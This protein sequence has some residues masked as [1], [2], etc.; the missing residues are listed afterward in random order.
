MNFA[1]KNKTDYLFF[2]QKEKI[3]FAKYQLLSQLQS[4]QKRSV[5]LTHDLIIYICFFV[6]PVVLSCLSLFLSLFGNIVLR[7]IFVPLLFISIFG[8]FIL[9]PYGLYKLCM[10]GLMYLFNIYGNS[11]TLFGNTISIYTYKMEENYCLGKLKKLEAYEKQI[12]EWEDSEKNGKPLPDYAYMEQICDKM[13]LDINIKVAT[14][15][16]PFV[17]RFGKIALILYYAALILYVIAIWTKVFLS[18]YP[19]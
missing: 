16:D 6:I 19:K 4:V 18:F 17:K 7:V 13:E 15:D 10:G 12:A 14:M 1:F 5:S 9:T 11:L 2:T 3:S 8:M